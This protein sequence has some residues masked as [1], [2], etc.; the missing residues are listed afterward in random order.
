[1]KSELTFIFDFLNI[2]QQTRTK[3]SAYFNEIQLILRARPV[4]ID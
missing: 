3:I 4:A 2:S 1:M